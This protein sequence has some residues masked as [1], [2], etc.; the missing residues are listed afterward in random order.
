MHATLSRMYRGTAT[1]TRIVAIRAKAVYG[2]YWSPSHRLTPIVMSICAHSPMYGDPDRLV[3]SANELGSSRM[4]PS[5]Y[6]VRVEELFAAFRFA[7]TE[8]SRANEESFWVM[9]ACGTRRW[10]RQAHLQLDEPAGGIV[11]LADGQAEP[12]PQKPE[13]LTAGPG[14]QVFGALRLLFGGV[15]VVHGSSVPFGRRRPGGG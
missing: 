4:R 3:S 6:R 1:S 14:D 11:H 9:R 13:P 7:M 10:S 2:V 5:A 12:V 8:L 15:G